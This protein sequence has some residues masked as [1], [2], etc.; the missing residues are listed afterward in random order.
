[1]CKPWLPLVK[2]VVVKGSSVSSHEIIEY[3]LLPSF[4]DF[5]ENALFDFSF[6]W[7]ACFVPSGPHVELEI[8]ELTPLT[9][10][11][12]CLRW[13]AL[14]Q[15]SITLLITCFSFQLAPTPVKTRSIS[16]ENYQHSI[17]ILESSEHLRA[18]LSIPQNWS[19]V[20]C[21]VLTPILWT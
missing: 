11:A 21:R 14:Q 5:D 13:C 9:V 1:M 17:W 16:L 8:L 2:K 4:F 15:T 19:F 20:L 18:P 6:G 7:S 12:C 3:L 10:V